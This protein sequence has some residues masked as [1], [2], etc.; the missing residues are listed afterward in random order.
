M[1]EVVI[2]HAQYIIVCDL[3]RSPIGVTPA[4]DPDNRGVMPPGENQCCKVIIRLGVSGPLRPRSTTRKAKPRSM[5]PLAFSREATRGGSHRPVSRPRP[6]HQRQRQTPRHSP[7]RQQ[8]RSSELPTGGLRA[9]GMAVVVVHVGANVGLLNR[10]SSFGSRLSASNQGSQKSAG[11]FS[12][13]KAAAT[14]RP[15][16]SRSPSTV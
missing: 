7:A 9:Q 11:L 1:P 13:F 14:Y 16:S 15:A 8:R 5:S 3:C 10:G 6:P 2:E 12:A 4:I